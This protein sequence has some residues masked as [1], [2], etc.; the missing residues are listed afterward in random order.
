MSE[1][2]LFRSY[3]SEPDSS[4][5]T[6]YETG[7]RWELGY[8]NE[9]GRSWRARYFEFNDPDFDSSNFLNLEY[10]D[11]EYA[12]RFSLGCNWR[13]ELSGG[14]RWAS[15]NDEDDNQY[16]DAFGL[17]VGGQ[18]RGPCFWCLESYALA[19]SMQYSE[20]NNS[21]DY[22]TFSI[23]GSVSLQSKLAS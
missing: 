12:G 19:H 14:V 23:S 1:L 6:E 21:E 9:C 13:G 7:S 5:D 2:L 4:H 18:L 8:M 20:G 17:V 10:L 11:I 22:G 15:V 16:D 3:D